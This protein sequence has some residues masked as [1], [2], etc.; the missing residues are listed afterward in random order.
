MSSAPDGYQRDSR[1]RLVPEGLIKPVDSTRSLLVTEI[2]DRVRAM[3]G[4]LQEFREETEDEIRAFLALSAEEYDVHYGGQRGNLNLVSFDGLLKIQRQI[5][6][7]LSF[8]ERMQTAKK[9]IDECLADWSEG[10]DDRIRLIV[11]DAFQVDKKGKIST[12]RVL[13]LRRIQIKD[14]KWVRAMSALSDSIQVDSS[15]SYLRFYER[16]S[17]E[18]EWTPISL[19]FSSTSDVVKP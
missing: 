6:D 1:G 19:D 7:Q 15:K 12:E 5:S 16:E 4:V 3:A 10:S 11:Q 14:E 18:A 2:I 9:L 13:G 17:V 8:D